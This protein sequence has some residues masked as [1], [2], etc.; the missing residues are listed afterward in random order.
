M[1]CLTLRMH[2]AALRGKHNICEIAPYQT[3]ITIVLQSKHSEISSIWRTV[4]NTEDCNKTHQIH[5]FTSS[6]FLQMVKRS[7]RHLRDS[8]NTITAKGYSHIGTPQ[9]ARD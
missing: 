9:G 5:D 8:L 3:K 1:G 2:Y 6:K 7:R 4:V